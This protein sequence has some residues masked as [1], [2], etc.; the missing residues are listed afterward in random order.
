MPAETMILAIA[1]A[2]LVGAGASCWVVS[3][4]LKRKFDARLHRAVGVMRKQ[5]DAVIDKMNSAHEF[6]KKELERLRSAPPRPMGSTE[7]RSALARLEEQLAAAYAELDR[8]R[9]EVKGPAPAGRR[10]RS[11]SQG[12]GA[13]TAKRSAAPSKQDLINGFAVTEVFES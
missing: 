7:Q 12:A 4:S 6:A 8:L 13:E 11:P 9:L 5:H 2:L 3:R 10:S 1:A